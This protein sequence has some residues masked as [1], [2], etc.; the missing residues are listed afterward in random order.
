MKKLSFAVK[1]SAVYFTS[2]MVPD[3]V[4]QEDAAQY[5]K[6]NLH[7]APITELYYASP[8]GDDSP[9]AENTDVVIEDS[10]KLEGPF[11]IQDVVKEIFLK[12]GLK[13]IPVDVDANDISQKGL[14]V[15]RGEDSPVI[16]YDEKELSWGI[17]DSIM[18]AY[19]T[20]AG[21]VTHLSVN[22]QESKWHV[23]GNS[24][25]C[26]QKKSEE[27]IVKKEFLNLEAYVRYVFPEQF[28][29][30]TVSLKVTP[31]IMDALGAEE[32]ELWKWARENT[33]LSLGFV[34]AKRIFG[35]GRG[36]N[37]GSEDKPKIPLYVVSRHPSPFGASALL[38]PNLFKKFCE[39]NGWSG[40]K[41]FP[42]S[43]YELMVVPDLDVEVGA[44]RELVARINEEDVLPEL[45]LETA[46]YIYSMDTNTIT[47]L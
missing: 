26:V 18:N 19:R 15:I 6:D 29:C 33:E 47:I 32:E 16:I 5:A 13:V 35:F 42:S 30:R 10:C 23:Y 3:E 12:E 8:E 28:G 1:C 17:M 2:L 46:V 4:S 9:E 25:V 11:T 14:I 43:T 38:F 21:A 40:C 27:D 45:R 7:L 39:Q 20:D 34:D 41:I 31:D 44:C 24:I 22:F 36:L 37:G